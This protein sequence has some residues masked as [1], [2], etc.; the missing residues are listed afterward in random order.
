[1]ATNKAVA[2]RPDGKFYEFAP[3]PSGNT[4]IS[5]ADVPD[6]L[7]KLVSGSTITGWQYKRAA[8]NAVENYDATGKPTSIVQRTGQTTTFTYSI[9]STPVSIAPRAGSATI[10]S[11]AASKLVNGPPRKGP[12]VFEEICQLG[13][14]GCQRL[15][16][17]PPWLYSKDGDY[18]PRGYFGTMT[19]MCGCRGR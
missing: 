6:T 4:F 11:P 15:R 13:Y 2:L 14:K 1:M 8:D 16:G 5:E 10:S 7:T 3:P 19:A 18:T 12:Q 9:T 17:I